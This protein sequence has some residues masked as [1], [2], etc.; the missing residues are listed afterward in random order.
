M[1]D[2][3]GSNPGQAGQYGYGSQGGSAPTSFSAARL[4]YAIGFGVIAW[5]VFWIAVIFGAVQFV[6]VAIQGRVNEE[7]RSFSVNLIQYLWELVAYITFVRD[8]QPFP[9]GPFP[10]RH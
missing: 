3:G 9:V 8:E 5:F 10:Q 2:S 4:L 7:L 1:S 6:M